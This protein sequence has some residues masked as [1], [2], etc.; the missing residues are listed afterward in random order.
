[1]RATSAGATPEPRRTRSEAVRQVKEGSVAAEEIRIHGSCLPGF[2]PVR[3][4]FAANFAERDELGAAVAVVRNGRPVVDLWAGYADPDRTSLWQ[5]DTL[6]YVWSVTKAMASICVHILMERAGL[7]PDTPLAHYWPQFAAAGKADIPVRWVLSHRAG[8]AGFTERV[9]PADLTDWDKMTSLLAAQAPLWEP[10]TV[11][12]YHAITFGFLA[13][14]LVRRITGQ[15]V[16][17]FFAD[18]VAGPLRA[19]VHIGLA[20]R[21]LPRCS[22]LQ[23]HWY[24]QEEL[25]TLRRAQSQAHPAARAA[26]ANPSLKGREANDPAWRVAQ[27]PS[28]NG[29][30]TALGLAIVM[31]ALVDGN[32][33]L[34][35]TGTLRTAITGQGRCQDLVLRRPLEFT[36]GFILSGPEGNYGPNPGAFGHDG[37]GGS[38]AGADPATGLAF[39]YVTNRLSASLVSDRRKVSLVKSIFTCVS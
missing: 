2:E 6:T 21:D 4:A 19:D 20:E 13:G 7:D 17:E 15:S 30:A 28:V 32:E 23:A 36:L 10:G 39:A 1:M 16:G 9:T 33:R 34:Y 38:S 12:G 26:L 5:P 25:S 24:T 11:S 31:G 14:E 18:E 8:L 27:I 29:H 37:Y 35:S 22:T 3:A